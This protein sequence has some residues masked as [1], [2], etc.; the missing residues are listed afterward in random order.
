MLVGIELTGFQIVWITE[1]G[2][3]EEGGGEKFAGGID[4]CYSQR[5][6]R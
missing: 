2:Q 6:F 3:M 5:L 1:C 4:A